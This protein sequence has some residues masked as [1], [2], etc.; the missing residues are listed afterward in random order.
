M[1]MSGELI[2]FYERWPIEEIIDSWVSKYAKIELGRRPYRKRYS[3]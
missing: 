1:L 3:Q 2:Q